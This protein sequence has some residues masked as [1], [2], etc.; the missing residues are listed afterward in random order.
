MEADSS[1]APKPRPVVVQVPSA[2]DR[3]LDLLQGHLKDQSEAMR[4]LG[5]KCDHM[6]DK[7]ESTSNRVFWLAVAI[8]ILLAG[9]TGSNL[10]VSYAGATV[11]TGSETARP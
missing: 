11:Q 3:L 5:R 8:L 6:S 7:I 10:Y 2:E 4:E 9:A 1:S